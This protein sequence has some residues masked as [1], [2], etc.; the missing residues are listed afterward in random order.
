MP[1]RPVRSKC[2]VVAVLAA[3]YAVAPREAL[4]SP[5]ARFVYVRGLG[6]EA[7]PDEDTMRAAVSARLGYD[8]FRVVAKTTLTAQ[9]SRENGVFHG[10]VKLVDESGQERGARSLESRSDDCKDLG[11]AMALSMSIAL[12]PLSVLAPT[13]PK[14]PDPPPDPQ[15]P[16]PPPKPEAPPIATR[17]PPP[18]IAPPPPAPPPK[19]RAKLGLSLGAHG[20]FGVGPQAAFGLGLG[21]ELVLGN[22]S[23][24]VGGRLDVP[25]AADSPQGGKIRAT[26]V[27]GEVVPCLRA[28]LGST[29]LF[30]CGVLLLAGVTAESTE[31]TA[32]RS[33]STFFGAGGVRAG[34]DLA[35]VPRLHVR[36]AIDALGHFTPYGLAVNG[37]TVFSSSSFSGRAAL[38]LVTFF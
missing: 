1:R 29:T 5:I 31:V 30:G 34:L 24:G 37:V 22:V 13:T 4:A 25:S 21:A 26:L 33:Q 27:G 8:P 15:P 6:A 14:P 11:E 35:I 18:P 36:L 3:S 12:D 28:P 9:I 20:A 10:H 7:C 23:V 2:L 16:E 19:E 38:G 32:P 17:P